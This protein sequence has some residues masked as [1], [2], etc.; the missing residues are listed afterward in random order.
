MTIRIDHNISQQRHLVRVLEGLKT[1][2]DNLATLANELKSWAQTLATKLNADVG[3]TDTDYDTT[4]AASDVT[5]G[6]EK[7]T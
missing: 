2:V 3:V 1:D 5:S 6:V 4:I 7:G